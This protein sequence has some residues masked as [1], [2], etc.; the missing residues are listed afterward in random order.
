MQYISLKRLEMISPIVIYSPWYYQTQPELLLHGQMVL[1]MLISLSLVSRLFPLKPLHQADEDTTKLFPHLFL[2]TFLFLGVHSLLY[3]QYIASAH[4]YQ[5]VILYM[6]RIFCCLCMHGCILLM[7]FWEKPSL[8]NGLKFGS[9]CGERLVLIEPWHKAHCASVWVCALLQVIPWGGT[10]A[11]TEG[12][13][14]VLHADQ[15]KQNISLSTWEPFCE[16][17]Q[18]CI[19]P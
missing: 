13:D 17:V 14:V 10:H 2:S 18:L 8:G 16:R 1:C 6:C 15:S 11:T 4:F 12:T 7:L 3:I 5:G 9:S 19:C